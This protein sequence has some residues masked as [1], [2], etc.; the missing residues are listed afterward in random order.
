MK[1]RNRRSS[2]HIFH[3]V[4]IKGAGGLSA[5]LLGPELAEQ[6]NQLCETFL[7]VSAALRKKIANHSFPFLNWHRGQGKDEIRQ[8]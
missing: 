2:A 1:V 5:F 7:G 6:I 8:L 3:T 4:S